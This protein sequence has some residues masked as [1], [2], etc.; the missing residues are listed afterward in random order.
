M[1]AGNGILLIYIFLVRLSRPALTL[2][3]KHLLLLNIHETSSVHVSLDNIFI[4]NLVT[5]AYRSERWLCFLQACVIHSVQWG[6]GVED[7]RPLDDTSLPPRPGDNTSLPHPQTW[8]QHLPPGHGH[9]TSPRPP[10]RTWSQHLPPPQDLVTTPPSPQDL[11]TTP[12]SLPP[13]L[14]DLVTTPPS[15]P[16]PRTCSQHLS[17][18]LPPPLCAG[19]RY[20]SYWNVFL[21]E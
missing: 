8:S 19:G 12:P 21:L 18:S 7:H 14:R 2:S 6:G 13:P 5:P 9:N 1:L 10:P 16:P 15:L 17:P 4:N 3:K 20:T 11:V